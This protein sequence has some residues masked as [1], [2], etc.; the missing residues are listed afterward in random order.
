[1]IPE[2]GTR[3]EVAYRYIHDDMLLDGNSALNLATFVTTWME[4]EAAP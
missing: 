3:P 4:P 2:H 1:M